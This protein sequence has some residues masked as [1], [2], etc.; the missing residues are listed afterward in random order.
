MFGCIRNFWETG[1]ET[2]EG[3]ASGFLQAPQGEV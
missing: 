3:L 2:V 1:W